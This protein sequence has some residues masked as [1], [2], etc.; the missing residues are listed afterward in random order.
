MK[1]LLLVVF[2]T[3]ILA[4]SGTY[5]YVFVYKKNHHRDVQTEVAILISAEDLTK[6]YESNAKV[7]DS[8]YLNKAVEISGNI[9]ELEKTQEG[10]TIITIGKPDA[11]VNVDVYIKSTDA[12]TGKLGDK[13][14][15]KGR[16]IGITTNV[17]IDDAVIK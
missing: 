6:A 14:T 12:F 1:K 16:C 7:A 3:V 15:F 10:K 17:K 2:A 5:Y 13:I 4:A 11:F 9:I 8:L